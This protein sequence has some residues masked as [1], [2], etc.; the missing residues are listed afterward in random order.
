MEPQRPLYEDAPDPP[1]YRQVAGTTRPA[2]GKAEPYRPVQLG[3]REPSRAR[4]LLFTID[5]YP[6]PGQVYE[7]T[8]P[9]PLPAR[10]YAQLLINAAEYGQVYAETVM[11][12]EVMG[13]E[14]LQALAASPDMD[15]EDL[16]KIM[17]EAFMRAMGPYQ[18]GMGNGQAG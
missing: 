18:A 11:I 9:D 16:K 5:N 6:E 3:K 17:A 8:I 15:P 10:H 1:G 12:N 4:V 14:N 7:G 2:P 13:R